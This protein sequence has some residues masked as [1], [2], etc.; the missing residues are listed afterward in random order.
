MKLTNEEKDLLLD[1]FEYYSQNK[2][3]GDE[4][5][6]AVFTTLAHESGEMGDV[7][8]L[9]DKS[10]HLHDLRHRLR[11]FNQSKKVKVTNLRNKLLKNL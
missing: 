1:M 2:L 4:E 5:K 10:K 7:G 11:K 6:L 3:N 9:Y 8:E